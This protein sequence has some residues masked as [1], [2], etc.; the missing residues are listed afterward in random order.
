MQFDALGPAGQNIYLRGLFLR[1]RYGA[2]LHARC[3]N[4]LRKLSD[5]YDQALS[6]VDVLVT[7]TII[8]PPPKINING[9]KELGV[10]KM[11]SRTISATYNTATFNSTG[12]PALSL[13]VGF[14]PA[15][16]DENVKLPTGLQVVGRKF[17]DL[18]C[19]KFAASWEAANDWKTFSP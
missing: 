12:H 9:G 1:E 15:R 11:L 8:F 3:T 19:L 14:V 13:P 17:G 6:E 18:T 10:L 2:P 16:D 4:L 5:A 7:P